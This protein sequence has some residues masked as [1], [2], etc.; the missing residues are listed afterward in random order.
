MD[1]RFAGVVNS[2]HA[3]YEEL[4]A[5]EPVTID[6][7]PLGPQGGVYM[8]SRGGQHLYAGRTKRRIRDRL[9]AHVDATADDC[10]F[11]WRLAREATRHPPAYKKAG[12]QK[13]LLTDPDFRAAYSDAKR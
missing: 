12:G 2:L 9:R 5:M 4:M 11:A 8:F 7:A 13:E 3:K 10:P 6:T 1:A